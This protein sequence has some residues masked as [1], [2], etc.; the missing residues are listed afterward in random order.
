MVSGNI[1]EWQLKGP[2]H[3]ERST[4]STISV[5]PISSTF[6]SVMKHGH[7]Q[8]GNHIIMAP[9]RILMWGFKTLILENSNVS[10]FI[11]K[12]DTD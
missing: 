1:N 6:V 7:G 2:P 11:K 5:H 3:A 12:V 8:L 9:L 4:S 10:E